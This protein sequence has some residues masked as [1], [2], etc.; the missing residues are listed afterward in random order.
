[1][2]HIK[3]CVRNATVTR[4]KQ[5]QSIN[6]IL[7]TFAWRTCNFESEA[8]FRPEMYVFRTLLHSSRYQLMNPANV[9]L[10]CAQDSVQHTLSHYVQQLHATRTVP[11][12]PRYAHPEIRS[13]LLKASN[14]VSI[15]THYLHWQ[16]RL[17]R[18]PLHSDDR[19]S[20][21]EGVANWSH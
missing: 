13:T 17:H 1:M 14:D 11:L 15:L 12:H 9:L 16:N 2:Q 10:F 8:G 5:C 18:I 3:L 19:C 7:T 4:R 21:E 6:Y 20:G